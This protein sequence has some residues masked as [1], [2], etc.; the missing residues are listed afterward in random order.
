MLNQIQNIDWAILHWI[1]DTLQCPALDWLLPKITVLGNAG[2]LWIVV[3]LLLVIT[4]KYRKSGITI[5]LAMLMGAIVGNLFLKNTVARSRPCWLEDVALLIKNPSDY[6]FPSGHT[7]MAVI[8]A[9]ILARTN[10][11]FAFAAIPLAV[12][13]AF[14]RLYLYVHFPSDV[15]V[16]AILGLLIARTAEWIMAK[17]PKRR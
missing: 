2:I 12:V 7:M 9:A 13:I 11:K 3:A 15:F 6:S 5:L 14:S 10:R 1:R 16:A 17:I 4:K 8:S